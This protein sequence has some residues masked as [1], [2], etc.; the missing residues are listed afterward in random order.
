MRPLTR[1]GANCS[2]RGGGIAEGTPREKNAEKMITAATR[3][4]NAEEIV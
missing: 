3:V 1:W 2:A 4:E